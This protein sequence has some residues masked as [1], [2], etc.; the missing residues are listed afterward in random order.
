LE[1]TGGLAIEVEGT[2]EIARSRTTRVATPFPLSTAY[3]AGHSFDL[4]RSQRRSWTDH[5]DVDLVM[6]PYTTYSCNVGRNPGVPFLPSEVAVG[7]RRRPSKIDRTD[8][9][10]T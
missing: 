4:L 2:D 1:V 3:R 8:A 10:K 9:G 6:P 7:G 5:V